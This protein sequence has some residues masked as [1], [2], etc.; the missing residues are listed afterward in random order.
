MTVVAAL[1]LIQILVFWKLPG[2]TGACGYKGDACL[3]PLVAVLSIPGLICVAVGTLGAC[4]SKRVLGCVLI[5]LAIFGT[6]LRFLELIIAIDPTEG[7]DR[8]AAFDG[9]IG[10][11][12]TRPTDGAY[13]AIVAAVLFAG[14]A[15]VEAVLRLRAV[16]RA[17]QSRYLN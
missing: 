15:M 3:M 9:W 8:E 13:L 17:E 4:L 11:D 1:G 7:D 5:G 10:V 16:D 12:V 14:L 6:I 2:T